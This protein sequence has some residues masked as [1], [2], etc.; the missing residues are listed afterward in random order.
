MAD[1]N[2]KFLSLEQ[3]EILAETIRSYKILYDKSS[4]GYKE[5]DAVV[6]AWNDVAEKLEFTESGN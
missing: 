2:R 3:E 4:K 5:K 6:N 1:E